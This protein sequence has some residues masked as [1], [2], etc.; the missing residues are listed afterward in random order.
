LRNDLSQNRV[1]P[2]SESICYSRSLAVKKLRRPIR[3]KRL[4]RYIA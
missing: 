1:L 4:A 2:P 3:A